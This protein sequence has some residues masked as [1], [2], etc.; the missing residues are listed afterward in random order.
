M[1]RRTKSAALETR[2]AILDAA[3]RVFFDRGVG[4]TS[5][6][7]I[8][9]EANVTRGA[10][11][12]HFSGKTALLRAMQERAYRPQEE[13]IEAQEL[14]GEGDPLGT[15]HDVTIESI[16]RFAADERAKK[17]WSIVALRCEYVGEMEDAVH[18][19]RDSENRMRQVIMS[20]FERARDRGDLHPDWTPES[21]MEAST[22]AFKGLFTQWLLA[23]ESFDVVEV[24][25]LMMDALFARY[26]TAGRVAAEPASVAA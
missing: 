17:V 21:A 19:Y 6:T 26:R 11:Y 16:R 4:Q 15:L 18:C 25:T 24:G 3:E 1:V 10:I 23:R 14:A 20:F 8:A 9:A 7:H 12:W 2:T 13:F 22:C 5:L